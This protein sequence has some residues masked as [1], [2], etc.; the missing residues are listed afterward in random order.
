MMGTCQA[1][2]KYLSTDKDNV[3]QSHETRQ[4]IYFYIEASNPALL[5]Q[6]KESKKKP[7]IRD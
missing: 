5:Q 4:I 1:H 6:L 2:T 7:A 3:G